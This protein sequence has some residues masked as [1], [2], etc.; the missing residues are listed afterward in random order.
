MSAE[1]SAVAAKLKAM[2]SRFLTKHDYEELLSKKSV[3]DICFYLKSTP[4][5]SDVLSE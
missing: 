4:G 3:S 2:H 5:Y 1:Y